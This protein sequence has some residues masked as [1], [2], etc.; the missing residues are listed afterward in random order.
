MQADQAPAQIVADAH[1]RGL[2]RD[3]PRRHFGL[4]IARQGQ[5]GLGFIEARALQI[6]LDVDALQRVLERVGALVGAVELRLQAVD[7][8]ADGAQRTLARIGLGRCRRR[9]EQAVDAVGRRQLRAQARSED[10]AERREQDGDA[11]GDGA[12]PTD[13]PRTGRC[14]GDR[15]SPR[16]RRSA[17]C[18]RRAGRSARRRRCRG[19]SA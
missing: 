8:R 14:V 9:G 12:P 5:R 10:D 19:W 18:G 15:L 3:H 16:R 2:Q 17:G 13:A 6:E 4:A 1:E 11:S 7:L